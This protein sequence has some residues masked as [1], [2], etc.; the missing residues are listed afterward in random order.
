[1]SVEH[2]CWYPSESV[3]TRHFPGG[4]PRWIRVQRKLQKRWRGVC[5]AG[6]FT[7]GMLDAL[8]AVGKATR[9]IDPD[10]DP[11]EAETQWLARRR[12]RVY[13]A[14]QVQAQ[15]ERGQD[16]AKAYFVKTDPT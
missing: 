13:T 4:A 6:C 2:A 7:Y 3:C 8:T 15:R 14:E 1:M 16:L 12:R 11:Q 10:A 9:G 5:N